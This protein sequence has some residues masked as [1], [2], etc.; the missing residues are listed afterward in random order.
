MMKERQRTG[1]FSKVLQDTKGVVT[2]IVLSLFFYV[3]Y[4]PQ[5][6]IELSYIFSCVVL[7]FLDDKRYTRTGDMEEKKSFFF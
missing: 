3:L 1:N 2:V 6:K 7:E 5:R 4:D